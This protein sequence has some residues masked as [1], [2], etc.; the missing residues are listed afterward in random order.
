LKRDKLNVSFAEFRKLCE[1]VILKLLDVDTMEVMKKT[2]L[3]PLKKADLKLPE[4]Q[5]MNRWFNMKKFVTNSYLEYFDTL[6]ILFNGVLVC[7]VTLPSDNDIYK[8]LWGLIIDFMFMVFF[9]VL[10]LVRTFVLGIWE[11]NWNIFDLFIT[12]LNILGEVLLLGDWSSSVLYYRITMLFNYARFLRILSS[13]HRARSLAAVLFRLIK[14]MA[15]FI[16][17]LIVLFYTFAL[18]AEML[19]Q[20][21]LV[22]G[23]PKLA[24]TMYDAADYYNMITFNSFAEAMTTNFHLMIINNW[25]VTAQAVFA[26]QSRAAFLFFLTFWFTITITMI[27]IIIAFVIDSLQFL[28]SALQDYKAD[29]MLSN[30]MQQTTKN[31]ESLVE[32][33]LADDLHDKE[34]DENDSE[35][36]TL[37]LD[38]EEEDGETKN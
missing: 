21:C 12:I 30:I 16:A 35:Q 20:D 34:D 14:M 8:P 15:N 32:N 10:C 17:L 5:S 24:G 28:Y 13:T 2:M 38:E 19:F 36:V 3:D 26:C 22:L 6:M 23:N 27:N 11:Y 25:H 29:D 9:A 7:W 4:I 33:L 37:S 1:A 31:F 18:F